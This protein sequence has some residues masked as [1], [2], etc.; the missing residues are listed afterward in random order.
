[1]SVVRIMMVSFFSCLACSF[2]HAVQPSANLIKQRA[3][4]EQAQMALKQNKRGKFLELKKQLTAYPLYPYLDYADLVRRLS[5]AKSQEIE[6]FIK[7]YQGMPVSDRL[8]G[9]WLLLLAQRKQWK[10]F[11]AHYRPDDADSIPLRCDY[12]NALLQ[13]Q[14]KQKAYKVVPKLWL[15]HQWR[16]EVCDPVFRQWMQDDKLTSALIW[17]RL[18]LAID[19]NNPKLTHYLIT[20]LPKKLQAEVE[21]LKKV[22]K[23]PSLVTQKHFTSQEKH[24]DLLVF[25]IEKMAVRDPARA[26]RAWKTLQKQHKFSTAAREK[27]NR[28]LAIEL[29]TEGYPEAVAALEAFKPM[30]DDPVVQ[31]WRVRVAI[32]QEDWQDVL[33]AIAKLP[34]SQQHKSIWQ[35]WRARALYATGKKPQ[36]RYIWLRLS[37]QRS[38]YGFLSSVRMGKPYGFNHE[39]LRV[40]EK[41]KHAV[42]KVSGVVRARELLILGYD[43]RAR[44]EWRYAMRGL[45]E[46]QREAAAKLAQ[47]WRWYDRAIHTILLT[48]KRND[49][50]LRFPLGYR[51]WVEAASR[52]NNLPSAW[53]FA[54]IRQESL[55]T[56]DAKSSVGALGL[57]QLM[58]RTAEAEAKTQKMKY[59]GEKTLLDPELNIQLGTAHLASVYKQFKENAILATAAYNA[60]AHSVGRWLTLK[61]KIAP[62]VWID[63]I[64]WKET[65]HYV[66]NV[67]TY[68]IIYQKQ[69]D[70]RPNL[71]PYLKSIPGKAGPA[72]SSWFDRFWPFERA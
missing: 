60:G 59:E 68:T 34:K 64:P 67:L 56:T 35:Y 16:P 9:K 23:T 7:H 22:H 21:N 13:T 20:L 54:L 18:R 57:M 5:T 1:M 24:V 43:S 26:L 46:P 61:K 70:Q 36:A 28:F 53:V 47:E 15:T 48:K 49:L 42:E 31:H 45:T 33:A 8:R 3:Q 58:P 66:K 52:K 62:D 50:A 2:I 69:Q 44:R 29:A 27:I 71:K 14:Q 37:R 63:I 6:A 10:A 40:N 4:F 65:R 17:Q 11:L 41:S 19:Y 25:G 72:Y 12:A 51:D 38:Y 39:T 55:F 30:Q 32:G